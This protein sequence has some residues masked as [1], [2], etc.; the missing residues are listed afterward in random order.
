MLKQ[1]W[2]LVPK[3]YENG[4]KMGSKIHEKTSRFRNLRFIGFCREYN[5]KIVFLHDQG[6]QKSSKNL[7]KIDTKTKLEKWCQNEP[8]KGSQNEPKWTQRLK[9]SQKWA[10]EGEGGPGTRQDDP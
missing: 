6:C 8:Q 1:G 9:N 4:A 10:L 2:Q 3:L 5:V 7:L